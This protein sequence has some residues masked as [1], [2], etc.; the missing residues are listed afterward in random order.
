[1]RTSQLK[2]CDTKMST[3][4]SPALSDTAVLVLADLRRLACGDSEIAWNGDN[5]LK[6][7]INCRLENVLRSLGLTGDEALAVRRELT[8]AGLLQN[9]VIAQADCCI[10]SL[11]HKLWPL[12]QGSR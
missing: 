11:Y 7:S 8:E 1:M 4:I 6:L 2:G 3:S 12:P 9:E 5:I 10:I